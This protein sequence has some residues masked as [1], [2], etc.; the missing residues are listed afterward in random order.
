MLGTASYGDARGTVTAFDATTGLG[1]I[2]GDD[3]ASYPFHCT[4]I[5]DGTRSIEVGRAV[6]FTVVAGH[7]GRLE[8]A[9]IT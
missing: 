2:T 1:E 3:G 7:R 5:A 9:G 6:A 4:A 8:A